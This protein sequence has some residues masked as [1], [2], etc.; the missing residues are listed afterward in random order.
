MSPPGRAP[1]RRW[2]LLAAAG[3]AILAGWLARHLPAA[4][5]LAVAGLALAA[6]ATV[7]L[8]ELARGLPGEIHLARAWLGLPT[9]KA[10]A[11]YVRGLFDSYAD[12]YD[13]HL[14]ADL[15]YRVPNLLR[16]LVGDR[17]GD[18]RPI[19][20]DLGCGTGALGPL[21]R[22]LCRRLDGIDLSP[23]MLAR[24]RSRGLHDELVEGE[25]VAF[26]RERPGRY[27]LLLA[28]DVLPYLG[29]PAPLLAAAAG[30][31]RP[32]GRLALSAEWHPGEEAFALT[33]TG[34]F[35]HAP[36]VV[37]ALAAAAGLAPE[38]RLAAILRREAGRP[39]DGFGLLLRK[40]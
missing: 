16:D 14:F 31:L 4:L 8:R 24:A 9:R 10:P 37:E 6:V 2:P 27:D 25:L 34:R 11:A 12:R 26:L 18:A 32:G 15:D 19:A 40:I 23:G 33:R 36:A 21:F 1:P 29:D 7:L 5:G 20:A 30:A 35:A 3:S 28:A 17:F 39:V 13:A 22:G 38:Q